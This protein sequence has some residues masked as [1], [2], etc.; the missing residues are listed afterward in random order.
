MAL[1]D[2]RILFRR[3]FNIPHREYRDLFRKYSDAEK[4]LDGHISSMS[5]FTPIPGSVSYQGQT[6]QQP[7]PEVSLF[8]PNKRVSQ[9]KMGSDFEAYVKKMGLSSESYDNIVSMCQR[10]EA[11]FNSGDA[12]SAR[13]IMDSLEEIPIPAKAKLIQDCV[14]RLQAKIK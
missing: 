14:K 1:M 10:A 2:I 11:L 13:A 8:I 3:F 6:K 7:T 9:P 12:S 5:P 4:E